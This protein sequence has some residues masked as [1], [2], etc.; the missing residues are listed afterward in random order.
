MEI[1]ANKQKALAMIMVNL[2]TL[3]KMMAGVDLYNI[4]NSRLKLRITN[5]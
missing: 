5:H 3:T 2:L 1:E 4:S